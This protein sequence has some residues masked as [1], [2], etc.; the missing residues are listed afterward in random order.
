MNSRK[1]PAL[2]DRANLQ[3][4]RPGKESVWWPL[5]DFATYAAAGQTELSFFQ[6]PIG[7]SSKTLADTNM[8]SAGQLPANQSFIITGIQTVFFPGVDPGTLSVAAA[9]LFVNDMWEIFKSGYGKLFIGSKDYVQMAPI[10]A[11]PSQFRMGGF[12]AASDSTT[13]GATQASQIGYASF[14]GPE[15]KIAELAIPSN[16]NFNF[17]LHWPAVVATPS[18]VAGR[19]GVYLNG[20]LTRNSQ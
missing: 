17:S 13:A 11:F 1:P 14:A 7:Q 8:T 2:K 20:W 4:N 9:N 6:N 19:I 3:V 12:A 18:T 15:F 10:G 16:Q 5:Y